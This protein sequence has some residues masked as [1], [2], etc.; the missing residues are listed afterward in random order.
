MEGASGW[1]RT[2]WNI[3]LL[4]VGDHWEARG[5]YL[6]DRWVEVCPP[7]WEVDTSWQKAWVGGRAG[8]IKV[9]WEGRGKGSEGYGHG[10]PTQR[11]SLACDGGGWTEREAGAGLHSSSHLHSSPPEGMFWGF[12]L[13]LLSCS[14]HTFTTVTICEST[15]EWQSLWWPLSVEGWF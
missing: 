15:V 1:A 10:F 11:C 9:S 3:T 6:S 2:C 7:R 4:T 8:G 12:V 5:E 14:T 13:F